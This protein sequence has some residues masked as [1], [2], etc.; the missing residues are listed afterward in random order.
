VKPVLTAP[1]RSTNVLLLGVTAGLAV[2]VGTAVGQGPAVLVGV[3]AIGTYLLALRAF[4]RDVPILEA[5]GSALTVLA[6]LG[7]G[8]T[9]VLA[10]AMA[11]RA[12]AIGN[13]AVHE[14]VR[15]LL[16]A[17]TP[18]LALGAVV[19]AIAVTTDEFERDPVRASV[20]TLLYVV[21]VVGGTVVAVLALNLGLLALG[22]GTIGGGVD[23]G[24][25]ILRTV[26]GHNEFAMLATLALLGGLAGGLAVRVHRLPRYV[27]LRSF[28]RSAL[29]QPDRNAEATD[30]RDA[31]TPEKS[32][33]APN[34][35]VQALVRRLRRNIRRLPRLLG[36]LGVALGV[37]ALVVPS[38]ATIA[39]TTP[40]ELEPVAPVL[41]AL[42]TAGWLRATLLWT[43]LALGGLRI[44][45]VVL[46]WAIHFPWKRYQRRVTRSAGGSVVTLVGILFG[47]V[48]VR[49]ILATPSIGYVYALPGGRVPLFEDG[50]F[51][52]V[53]AGTAE[54]GVVHAPALFERTVR[55]IVDA[56]GPTP[57]VLAPVL[58]L[59]LVGAVSLVVTWYVARP[60]ANTLSSPPILAGWLLFGTALVGA[61]LDVG[62]VLVLAAGAGAVV[63]WDLQG[64]T[65]SLAIQL[66]PAAKTTRGEL[67]RAGGTGLIAGLGV[68]IALA[69]RATM[70]SLGPLETYPEWQLLVALVCAVFGATLALV[71]LSYRNE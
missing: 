63:V 14:A 1:A 6:L 5:I 53:A 35:R 9:V 19:C 61:I 45:H 16:I 17:L 13:P 30:A 57:F 22:I 41:G 32:G 48:I 4:A 3:L 46:D 68:G 15:T 36:V 34:E 20:G 2:L 8:G 7:F 71:Y 54:S 38:E 65:R 12:P 60:V 56:I 44:A 69:G 11:V 39:G 50:R 67:V 42:A 27:Q 31:E 40:A 24:L 51:R 70:R 26:E 62:L 29:S 47:P 64:L 52:T 28:V 58:G 10:G 18:G 25:S 33:T 21:A 37:T 43:A 66:D 55:G 49:A 59:L 23:P